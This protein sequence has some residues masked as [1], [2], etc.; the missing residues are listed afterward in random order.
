MT[1][2]IELSSEEETRL[3]TRAR[4]HGLSP[5]EYAH[6]LLTEQ[7]AYDRESEI[8]KNA[9][10]IALLESWLKEDATDDPGEIAQAEKDLE[11]FKTAIDA[12]RQRAGAR[13]IYR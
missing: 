2:T 4:Q 5:E 1:L 7:P 11:E 8:E 12:E 13:T 6:R 9:A 10:S 3:W